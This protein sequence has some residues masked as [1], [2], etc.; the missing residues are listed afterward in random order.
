VLAACTS[1]PPPSNTAAPPVKA[2]PADPAEQFKVA[3]R[4][5]VRPTVPHHKDPLI[6]AI[7]A[8]MQ[9]PNARYGVQ[10]TVACREAAKEIRELEKAAS[11]DYVLYGALD[12]P[13]HHDRCWPVTFEGGM[14][15]EVVG[16]I[17]ASTGSLVL[18]WRIPE[19]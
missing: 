17:D 1:P 13:A 18:A 12:D 2:A 7:D 14:K 19:G 5:H 8:A 11:Y 4:D 10:T 3:W 15:L 16:Y 9:Q 6:K